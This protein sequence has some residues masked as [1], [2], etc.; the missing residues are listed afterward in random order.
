MKSPV[1]AFLTVSIAFG[2]DLRVVPGD[3]LRTAFADYLTANAQ[4]HIRAR[5]A[6][7]ASLDT[8]AKVRARQAFIR[9]WLIDAMGGFPEKTPLNPRITGRLQRDGYRVELLV[10]ES[11]PKFY[12][13]ANVYVPTGP[14]P[15]PAIVGTAG[16][17]VTGKAIGTYQQAWIGLVKRGFVVLA[18]DPPGQGERLEYFD[19]KLKRSTVGVGTSEHNMAGLQCLLTGTTFARYETWDGIRALDYLLTR[20][21]VDPKRVG[22]AGNSGGGTQS[23]YLAAVEPRLAA[24][25]ISCYMTNWEQLWASPGPQDSEQNFPGFLSSGLNFGDFMM[26]FAPRPVMMLTATRDYF[27]IAGGHATYAEVKRVFGVMDAEVRAGFYE[28]DSEHGW[29]QPRREATTRWMMK[30]LQGKDDDAREAA[31]QSEPELL[32]N[33]TPTGQVATS[34]GGETVRS[35]NAALARS[36]FA[37]R[38]AAGI[39]D[40]AKLRALIART[41]NLPARSRP[42]S[43]EEK[44]SVTEDGLNAFKFLIGTEPGI[45]IPALLWGSSSSPGKRPAAIYINPKGKA[46]D[47]GAIRKLVDAGKLVL[48]IDPR[49]WGESAPPPRTRDY[50]AEWQMA[51]RALLIGKPL[52]AMQ[53]FDA[54][55]AFDWLLT[56]PEVDASRIG[57]VGTGAGGVVALFAAAV[58]PRIASAEVSD[59]LESYMRLAEADTHAMPI[60]LVI[61]GVL[62]HFDLPD[63]ARAIAPRPLRIERPSDGS[64]TP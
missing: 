51:Q 38:T 59:S 10:F 46:A 26:A 39:T 4:A 63:V 12:V 20:A 17:S 13:T 18:F 53:T 24:S 31:V 9:K 1:L 15:F 34:F 22:V 21:D 28:H 62:K 14:G 32:L 7:V 45:R 27:P 47:P 64:R 16:H 60:G 8:P 43:A 44:G 25:A 61:P 40:P 6:E 36:L 41:L 56:L 55:R 33:V 52:A 42:A 11:M 54:L 5:A 35:I 19:P 58:E 30:W 48:S 50:S 3:E 37:K 57:V 23:A 49:G 29:N 2:A